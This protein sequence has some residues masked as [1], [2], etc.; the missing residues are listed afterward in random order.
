MHTDVV[1]L[2]I[3]IALGV[4]A[5]AARA[6]ER[7]HRSRRSASPVPLNRV[8]LVRLLVPAERRHEMQSTTPIGR[9][10][11]GALDPVSYVL[12][13]VANRA[14][15][16]ATAVNDRSLNLKLFADVEDSVLDLYSAPGTATCSDAGRSSPWPHRI[17][18]TNG[19]GCGSRPRSSRRHRPHRPGIERTTHEDIHPTGSFP[20]A[21]SPSAASGV[22]RGRTARPAPRVRRPRSRSWRL[23]RDTR[24]RDLGLLGPNG[25]GK[26]TLL[27][28]VSTRLRPTS[29]DAWVHGKHVTRDVDAVR[30]L[31]NVAPQE[32]ALYPSLTAAEN[33]SFFAELYEVPRSERPADHGSARG[34][35][36]HRPQG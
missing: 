31:L 8:S 20:R 17:A 21:T 24:G 5:L 16:I 33:M 34:R 4:V 29:G 12:P 15:S 22:E 9:S 19:R 6:A 27:S 1:Q 3:V 26:T 11:D 23:A 2:H 14:K 30:R 28:M 35:R 36:A 25:A 7:E 18:T 32:E 13:F 10:I